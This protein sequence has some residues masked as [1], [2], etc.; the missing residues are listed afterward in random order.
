VSNE[1]RWPDRRPAAGRSWHAQDENQPYAGRTHRLATVMPP[2]PPKRTLRRPR[3]PATSSRPFTAQ[4]HRPSRAGASK[5][6]RGEVTE[7]LK[8]LAW[9][10]SAAHKV[11]GGSNPPLSASFA[12]PAKVGSA[13]SRARGRREPGQVRKEAAISVRLL[14]PGSP[15]GFHLRGSWFF[16]RWRQ[17]DARLPTELGE[18]PVKVL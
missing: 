13:G 10:A 3:R 11:A 2:K 1:E 15:G 14:V 7:R 4:A 5:R 6:L 12:R 17:R 18:N 16:T 8:E 9:K